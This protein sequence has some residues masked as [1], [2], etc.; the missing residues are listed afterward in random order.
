MGR[1]I[2][3]R[4]LLPLIRRYL[5]A[6]LMLNG[7]VMERWE[8]TPQGG[9]LSP[10][11]AN[12]L[13]EEVDQALERRGHSFARYAD[14]CNVY[15]RSRRAGERVMEALRKLYGDLRLKINEERSAV[16]LATSRKFLGYSFR[17]GPKG[18]VKL[19]V[20][21]KARTAMKERVR[22]ITR[23]SRGRGMEEVIA[24]LREFLRGW[25]NSFRLAE[26]PGVFR[27]LDEWIRHR[28]RARQLKLWKR[29]TTMFRE[30][31]KLGASESLAAKIAAHGRRWWSTSR[32]YLHHVL[33]IR[34]FDGWGLPRLAT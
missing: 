5:E 25:K 21:G 6:G 7:V 14:D 9:P 17:Y 10:L 32:G 1:R 4:R 13:P 3:D 8:G 29:G 18:T 19:R 30:L 20:A 31:C 22:I 16:A 15:V 23:R 26:T 12:I 28:L 34:T 24:D 33:T 27:D 11:L 2:G